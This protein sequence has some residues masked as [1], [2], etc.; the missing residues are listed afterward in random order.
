VPSAAPFDPAGVTACYM[1]STGRRQ[2]RLHPTEP[3]LGAR[4]Y[5]RGTPPGADVRNLL[6]WVTYRF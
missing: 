6:S 2:R 5:L 4:R 1:G 3:D